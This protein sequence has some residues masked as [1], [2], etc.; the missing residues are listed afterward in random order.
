MQNTAQSGFIEALGFGPGE[1]EFCAGSFD[2]LIRWKLDDPDKPW[3]LALPRGALGY[4][5]AV[6]VAPAKDRALV[7]IHNGAIISL[8]V[9]S[10]LKINPNQAEPLIPEGGRVNCLWFSPKGDRFVYS[11]LTNVGAVQEWPSGQQKTS[12]KGKACVFCKGGGELVVAVDGRVVWKAVDTDEEF[13]KSDAAK[14]LATAIAA[15]NDGATVVTGNKDS[16]K[17]PGLVY[18]R[19]NPTPTPLPGTRRSD[20]CRRDHAGRGLHRHWRRGRPSFFGMESRWR[21]LAKSPMRTTRNM[22]QA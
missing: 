17:N 18:R 4:C 9:N 3:P 20:L 19:G 14:D 13:F 1:R 12:F 8:D 21:N 16:G 11:R 5:Y 7:A 2:R 15:S 22:V 6:A 10:K